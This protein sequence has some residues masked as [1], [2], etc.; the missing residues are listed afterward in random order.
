MNAAG[1]YFI[2]IFIAKIND[3]AGGF[4]FEQNLSVLLSYKLCRENRHLIYICLVN[5]TQDYI[6]K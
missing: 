3:V 6:P 1:R 5:P 4:L 2:F